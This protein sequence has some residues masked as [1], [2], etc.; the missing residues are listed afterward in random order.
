[1]FILKDVGTKGGALDESPLVK[2][3]GL[4]QGKPTVYICKG[5]TCDKPITDARELQKKIDSLA[6][7]LPS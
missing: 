3:R 1:V 4:Q 5:Y 6:T 7:K 2:E